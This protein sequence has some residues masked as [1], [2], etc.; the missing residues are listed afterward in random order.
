MQRSLAA[1]EQSFMSSDDQGCHCGPGAA[2]GD[3]MST[4]DMPVW[5]TP[6]LFCFNLN[7]MGFLVIYAHV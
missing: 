4:C 7:S 2:E 1:N 5:A 3:K 6:T